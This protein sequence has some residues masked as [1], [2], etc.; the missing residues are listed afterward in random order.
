MISELTQQ[1]PGMR[2]DRW[3]FTAQSG[4][5]P[6]VPEFPLP[7]PGVYMVIAR[8]LATGSVN[9]TACSTWLVYWSGD[10]T[11]D[12]TAAQQLGST[13]K[14]SGS[15]LAGDAQLSAPSAS[16]VVTVTASWLGGNNSCRVRIEARKIAT[17]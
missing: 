12:M 15:T 4:P 7:E 8:S 9:H 11:F 6:F 10:L 2:I 16:G 14:S 1:Q 5:S 17:L 3:A 13:V